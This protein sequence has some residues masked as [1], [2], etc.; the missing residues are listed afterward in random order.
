MDSLIRLE[1][2]GHYRKEYFDEKVKFIFG[3][4]IFYPWFCGDYAPFIKTE[5]TEFIFNQIFMLEM[6]THSGSYS[7][8]L[9][10]YTE[11]K[12]FFTTLKVKNAFSPFILE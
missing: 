5:N 4:Y 2:A 12:R 8:H 6:I 9:D 3:C 1:A 7:N 10:R 11:K